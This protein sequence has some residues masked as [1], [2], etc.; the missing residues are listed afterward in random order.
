M[1]AVGALCGSILAGCSE[2]AESRASR[3]AVAAC[4]R[5]IS[6]MQST[7]DVEKARAALSQVQVSMLRGRDLAGIVAMVQGSIF[8]EEAN[9]KASGAAADGTYQAGLAAVAKRQADT[10]QALAG[11]LYDYQRL[12]A[13]KSRMQKVIEG[14]QSSLAEL[15][16]LL[17]AA[18][19]TDSKHNWRLHRQS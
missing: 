15:R 5:A 9:K 7:G 19:A 2:D 14:A 6:I 16:R 17:R 18:M 13:E 3:E 4:E 8:V 12:E 1:I 11:K 10:M